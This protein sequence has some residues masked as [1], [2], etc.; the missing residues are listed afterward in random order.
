MKPPRLTR[1]W[2]IS[3]SAYALVRIRPKSSKASASRFQKMLSK[4]NYVTSSMIKDIVCAR[5]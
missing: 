1:C 2:T 5:R 4:R 3:E